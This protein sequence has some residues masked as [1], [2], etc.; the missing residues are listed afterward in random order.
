[1]KFLIIVAL[2]SLSSLAQTKHMIQF[3]AESINLG[4]LGKSKY[5]YKGSSVKDDDISS[6]FLN[7]GYFYAIEQ[8]QV[9]GSLTYS[10][11]RS[12][13][14]SNTFVSMNRSLNFGGFYNI[15]KLSESFFIGAFL[16]F[17]NSYSNSDSSEIDRNYSR[18]GLL[19]FGKRFSLESFGINGLVYSPSISFEK[20][21]YSGIEDG[22]TETE[23][24]TNLN[25]LK[26]SY[27]F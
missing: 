14:D 3:D 20:I 8:F 11:S 23:T 18:S 2:F 24:N 10:R 7:L 26:I 1:M 17:G 22:D 12:N 16:G 25:F 5:E 4:F 6:G 21:S 27:L 15:G 19:E 9:G 13:F